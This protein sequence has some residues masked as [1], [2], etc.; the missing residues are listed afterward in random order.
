MW[1]GLWALADWTNG[2][3]GRTGSGQCDVGAIRSISASRDKRSI[4][5]SSIS[6]ANHDSPE[7]ICAHVYTHVYT[8]IYAHAYAH[9]YIHMSVHMSMHT[10]PYTHPYTCLVARSIV[11]QP[12]QPRNRYLCCTHH[13]YTHAESVRHVC[14]HVYVCHVP[15]T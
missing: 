7:P 13:A 5:A 10:C 2:L 1:V 12:Q 4:L 8:G 15:A 14:I 9:V 6:S 11:C 3:W